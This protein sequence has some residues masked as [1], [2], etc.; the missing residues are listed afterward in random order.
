MASSG[1]TGNK[2]TALA[3]LRRAHALRP[4][5][6]EYLLGL[7]PLAVAQSELAVAEQSLTPTLAA[8][9]DDALANH[10]MAVILGQ[11]LRAPD[12]LASR[13]KLRATRLQ[14]V[15]QHEEV[16]TN[17]GKLYLEANRTTDAEKVY[18]S[19]LRSAP[20]SEAFLSGLATCYARLG[21][22]HRLP[23]SPHN[24]ER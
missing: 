2:D 17:L 19:G 5:D 14:H 6:R 23:P 3:A 4:T 12:T 9:P 18:R 1:T 10:W 8:H 20:H 15:V 22:T 13:P 7:W 16:V 21:Q 11:K 24:C